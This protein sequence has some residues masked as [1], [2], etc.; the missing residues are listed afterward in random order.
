MR[1]TWKKSSIKPGS[2]GY[3]DQALKKRCES[4]GFGRTSDTKRATAKIDRIWARFFIRPLLLVMLFSLLLCLWSCSEARKEIGSGDETAVAK[5]GDTVITDEEI[6]RRLR[7]YSLQY[8]RH[9]ESPERDGRNEYIE[10]MA[11]GKRMILEAE[12]LGLLEAEPSQLRLDMAREAIYQDILYR[13]R[14]FNEVVPDQ[15]L[16]DYY[17]DHLEDYTIPSMTHVREIVVTPFKD[18]QIK[19][20][21]GDDAREK[22]QAKAKIEYLLELL[23]GGKPFEEIAA[24][25]SEHP[26]AEEGGDRGWI[27][28][29]T[30]H[31]AVDEI[32]WTLGPGERSG[33]IN[34]GS[35]F[36]IVQCV[37][38]KDEKQFPF[39]EVE[40]DV[41]E[42]LSVLRAPLLEEE[43]RKFFEDLRKRYPLEF[44]E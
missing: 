9:L 22:S 2:A 10:N 37:D 43:Q 29:R 5:V 12:R 7:Q 15:A 36:H 21:K 18:E 26:S 38:R 24:Q 11:D 16:R 32:L 17:E 41:V 19:N 8:R 30:L 31:P 4:S 6:D 14:I 20:S 42:K 35:S 1:N 39:E 13:E 40:R 34:D 28:R 3:F 23:E 25:Y 44:S 33:I 27:K